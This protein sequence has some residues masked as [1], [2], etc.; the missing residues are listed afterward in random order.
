[1][2]D[3]AILLEVFGKSCIVFDEDGNEI[4]RREGFDKEQK[5]LVKFPV[6]LKFWKCTVKGAQ[7]LGKKIV[8]NHYPCIEMPNFERTPTVTEITSYKYIPN[9]HSP[10]S[11]NTATGLML[12]NEYFK[13]LSYAKR[14]FIKNHEKGHFFYKTEKYCDLYATKALLQS[15]F[16]LSQCLEVLRNTLKDSPQKEE[17]YD[18][19]LKKLK[20]G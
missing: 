15:G 3:S 6:S 19:V 9:W 14:W 20:N 17:R 4:T 2:A 12:F 16:G 7:L 1:M 11:I 5:F 10:A 13:T 18:Y 8:E